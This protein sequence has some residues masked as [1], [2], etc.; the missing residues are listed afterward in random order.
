MKFLREP[1]F[2]MLA[3]LLLGWGV[4]AGLQ[5]P[6]PLSKDA[7]ETY[8]S[9]ARAA[10]VLR[11][12]YPDNRA[13]VAGSPENRAL[14]E[15]IVAQF[16]SLDYQVEMQKRF[17]CNA[18]FG[19]CS[20]VENILAFK[21]GVN[22]GM[23]ILLTAHYDSAWSGLGVADDGA[24][25]AAIL[26]IARLVNTQPQFSNDLIFL[27]SDG[28]EQGLVGADAFALEHGLFSSVRT[29]IN[30]EARG[31]S[32]ASVMFET[33]E[34]N[35]GIIRMLEKNLDRP[36]A[37][38]LSYEVYR[39]MP[40]DTDFSVYRGFG[41]S[42]V[43]FAFTG[44]AAGYHS[45]IDDLDHLD[46]G[47]LQHHGDNAWGMLLALDER[48]LDRMKSEEDAVYIDLFGHTL[49]HYPVSS[50]IG[51]AL[52]LS[53]LVM[54]AIRRSYYRQVLFL[55]V[56]WTL[57][58]LGVLTVALPAAGWLLSW[59]LGRWVDMNPLQHPVPW[60]GRSA[61]IIATILILSLV[62]RSL[63]MRASVGSVMTACWAVFA[64]LA[65]GL[66]YAIPVA[67]FIA[68]LPLLGFVLG[69]IP[70]GFRWKEEPRLVFS[71]LFGFLAAT[72]VG[73]YFFFQLDVALNFDMSAVRILP[74]L[75]PVIASLPLLLSHWD[76]PGRGN[77]F[78][79]VLLVALLGACLGQ[80]FLPAY[81]PEVPRD[82]NLMYRHDTD[83]D[84]A[85]LVLESGM[86][87]PDP[88]FAKNHGFSLV[89]LPA[90]DGDPRQV[91]AR[92]TP[93]LDLPEVK[94]R[95]SREEQSGEGV[96]GADFRLDL[97]IPEG[98]RLVAVVF[99]AGAG[100][101]LA[102]VD[103]QLAFDSSMESK[104]LKRNP[105]LVINHPRPGKL[106]LDL[107]FTSSGP[108]E[109]LLTARFDFPPELQTDYMQDWPSNAMPAF[110]GPRS[111][112]TG[113]ITLG[114]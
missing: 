111:L 57:I 75:L 42:G 103:G 65:L 99:P 4:Y 2:L 35:R 72:Y 89:D 58:A 109:A 64:L 34:G 14:A 33:G 88:A 46:L 106:R 96:V 86:G 25:V 9:A 85:L 59:P 102:R 90:F 80:Q 107:Q 53:V 74:L 1:V 44:G 101:R 26:E 13:H 47:S 73:L 108:V 20:P 3:C 66:A 17:H 22:P 84:T 21:P 105:S 8:F 5:P 93:P 37:N 7:P 40:N 92:E 41:L 110:L 76:R 94:Y 56:L 6:A 29:V 28:E 10:D 23:A 39:R 79:Y 87:T 19:R 49:L 69:L 24:G 95:S 55:Q 81:T 91:L 78:S 51:L 77:G 62:L 60:L 18:A 27:L 98:T 71:S 100:L 52:V 113:L 11:T 112:K 43:N 36:V 48:N 16:R 70:D 15:R 97:E 82:M 30:L 61:L 83:Q 54:I 32:G 114:D 63:A 104:R 68:V 67:G 38:S 12:L 50:A 31:T 45:R